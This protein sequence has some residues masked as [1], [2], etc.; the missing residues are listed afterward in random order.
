MLP[1]EAEKKKQEVLRKLKG[2]GR[3]KASFALSRLVNKIMEAGIKSQYPR[4]SANKLKDQI[5]LRMEKWQKKMS[6]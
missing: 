5:I 1:A 6:F 4:I 3:L 2:A